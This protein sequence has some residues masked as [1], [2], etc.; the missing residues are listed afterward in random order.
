MTLPVVVAA[1]EMMV[2][3]MAML[4]C[5]GDAAAL[6]QRGA[7]LPLTTSNRLPQ[8]LPMKAVSFTRMR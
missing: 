6:G 4:R 3:A 5:M 8:R 1:V 2:T 7:P